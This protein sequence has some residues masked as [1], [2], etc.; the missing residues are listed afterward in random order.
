MRTTL[1]ALALLLPAA[2][3]GCATPTGIAAYDAFD[4]YEGERVSLA[5]YEAVHVAPVTSSPEIVAR[6]DVSP[7]GPRNRVRPLQESTLAEKQDDLA[8]EL[9]RRLSQV[10]TLRDAPGPGVLTV[11]A[12]LTELQ[13]NRPTMAELSAQPGLD[14]RSVSVGDAGVRITLSEDGRVIGVIDDRAVQRNFNDPTIGVTTWGTADQ[15]FARVAEKVA[16]LLR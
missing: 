6:I 13:A 4:A 2:L 15:Y 10:A 5:G 14:F 9:A 3:T 16:A 8:E 1:A 7:I 11:A 12:E